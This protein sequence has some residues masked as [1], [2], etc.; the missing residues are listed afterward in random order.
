M[1]AGT[2]PELTVTENV[3]YID[4]AILILVVRLPFDKTYKMD[5]VI[6]LC[7]FGCY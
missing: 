3:V 2:S 5:V 7:S 6:I 4:T 1:S